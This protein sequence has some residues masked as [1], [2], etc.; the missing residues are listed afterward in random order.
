MTGLGGMINRKC[1]A[2]EPGGGELWQ[3]RD[4][5]REPRDKMHFAPLQ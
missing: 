4:E 5:W 3:A 1:L 2:A